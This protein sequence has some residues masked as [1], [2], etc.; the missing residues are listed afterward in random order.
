MARKFSNFKGEL[1]PVPSDISKEEE[2]LK[3][4]EWI[5]TNLGP[6]SIL[7]NN[8][9]VGRH[10]LIL[11]STTQM[12]NDIFQVNVIGLCITTREVVKIMR[13]HNIN[14]HIININSVL[15]HYFYRIP[16]ANVY[17]AS[18]HAVTTLTE[19]LRVELA[20]LNTKIKITVRNELILSI[21]FFTNIKL[22]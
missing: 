10:S 4:I 6:I 1:V 8:A 16:I 11:D 2:I 13:E 20:S 21:Y 15:G 12:Y 7:I 5:K 18:K 22:L 3:A 14:G 17:P 9:G 19:S